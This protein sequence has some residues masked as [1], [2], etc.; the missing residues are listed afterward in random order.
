MPAGCKM[1]NVK[2]LNRGRKNVKSDI[3]LE[4]VE[5]AMRVV[6]DTLINKADDEID[7]TTISK[8]FMSPEVDANIWRMNVEAAETTLQY[9]FNVLHHHCYLLAVKEGKPKLY[10]LITS[11]MPKYFADKISENPEFQDYAKH[12]DEYRIL[13]CIVKDS[14]DEKKMSKEYVNFFDSIDNKL[15]NGVYILNL[16]DAVLLRKDGRTPWGEEHPY[17]NKQMIPILGGSGAVGYYDIPIPNYDDIRIVMGYTKLDSYETIWEKKKA[18]AVFRGSPSGCGTSAKTNMRIRLAEMKIDPNILDAGITRDTEG[19]VRFDP[20]DGLS[21]LNTTAKKVGFMNLYEQS[22]H[23]YLI[24]IDGN[25]AAYR[26]LQSMLTGSLILKVKGKYTLWVDHILEDGVH[27][28]GVKEDLSDLEEK[29]RWCM[30]HDKE[31]EKIAKAGFDFVERHLVGP[32]IKSFVMKTLYYS[33][34]EDGVLTP[35]FFGG[36]KKTRRHKLKN[37]RGTKRRLRHKK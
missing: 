10:K 29:I 13:Q 31:C 3:F 36:Y 11:G 9:I 28:V 20:I 35:E 19:T 8:K 24:H 12:L 6:N 30:E 16:T 4:S 32:F 22:K 17:A 26:L 14:G 5:E 2:P 1:M 21:V 7:I 25:V 34:H 18:K 37:R 27:Y 15:K 33:T 23:K